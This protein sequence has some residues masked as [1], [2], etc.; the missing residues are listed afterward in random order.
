ML[1]K[2]RESRKKKVDEYQSST[3]ANKN[4]APIGEEGPVESRELEEGREPEETRKPEDKKTKRMPR[5]FRGKAKN[6][7]HKKIDAAPINPLSES[8]DAAR[9]EE[10]ASPQTKDV[11]EE[12]DDTEKRVD[13]EKEPVLSPQSVVSIDSSV[14]NESIGSPASSHS[15][16]EEQ[17]RRTRMVQS[18]Q[19]TDS[20][21]STIQ[22][23]R[24]ANIR[25]NPETPD[26]HPRLV[27]AQ[28]TPVALTTGF[29][30]GCI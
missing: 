2:A 13:V 27:E 1:R 10:S 9:I 24:G 20:H 25:Y 21:I 6:D 19:S 22:S 12:S 5:F 26:S 16:V 29:L 30:C 8:V 3:N 23:P 7:N 14:S 28:D 11:K 15:S 4:L 18:I 17:D